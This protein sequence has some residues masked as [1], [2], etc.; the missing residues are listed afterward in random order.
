MG[1][2]RF[3]ET[4]EAGFLESVDMASGDGVDGSSRGYNQDHE[5]Q[6][7]RGT[8]GESLIWRKQGSLPESSRARTETS[9]RIMSQAWAMRN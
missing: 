5:R 2:R 6:P 1:G 8:S 9:R 3:F 7:G 4:R